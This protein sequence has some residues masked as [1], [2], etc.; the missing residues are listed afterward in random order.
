[1]TDYLPSWMTRLERWV[2]LHPVAGSR[3]HLEVADEL[4]AALAACGLV[5]TR[6]PHASGDL[7]VARGVGTGPRLGMYGH[8]D[9]EPGG[10][11]AMRVADNRIFGRGVADNLGPLTLRL[12]VL[13]RHSHHPNLLWVIEPGEE[14]G[15]R[16]LAEWL[17]QANDTR[18]DLWLDETGY[19]DAGGEQ[20]VL[21]VD[22]DERT[23][24]VIRR[25]AALA[26]TQGRATRVEARRLQRVAAG[27]RCMVESLFLDTPY[28]AMGP[29]DDSSDVHGE[30]ESLPL[31]TIE[32]S[33]RQFEVLLDTFATGEPR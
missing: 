8:Y 20:R 14:T 16:A 6:Y 24:R 23:D 26:A 29:N 11:T 2:H 17:G 5:V 25:C 10:R 1:M 4:A 33:I 7:L 18:A 15:S 27:A 19:F 22:A 30:Q 21:A 12:S 28:L 13:E 32:L 3:A 9:V 31:N